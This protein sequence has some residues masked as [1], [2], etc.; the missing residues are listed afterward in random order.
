MLSMVN[1][2]GSIKQTEASQEA[3]SNLPS[4]RKGKLVVLNKKLQ[5]NTN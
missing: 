5:N 2:I 4:S 1:K 3:R